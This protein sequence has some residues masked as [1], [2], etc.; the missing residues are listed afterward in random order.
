M[1]GGEND[2][3]FYRSGHGRVC[4]DANVAGFVLVI[5]HH[6]PNQPLFHGKGLWGFD[7]DSRRHVCFNVNCHAVSAHKRRL[8]LYPPP[9]ELISSGARFY[10]VINKPEYTLQNAACSPGLG[11]EPPEPLQTPLSPKFGR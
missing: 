11:D 9:A 6:V 8:V 5:R 4:M 3:Y 10:C 7:N 2:K 1:E